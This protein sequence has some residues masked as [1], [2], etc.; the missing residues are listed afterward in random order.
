MDPRRIYLITGFAQGFLW[1]GWAVA[2][3]PWWT[4]V[5]GLSPIQ[6]ILLGTALELTVLVGEVP[7][8][9]VADV[10]SRKWSVV[11]SWAVIAA[12]QVLAP[13]SEI[14]WLLIAWQVLWALGFTLQSGATTAW[15]T[16]ETGEDETGSIIRHAIVRSVGVIFGVLG[17]FAT[18]QI[19]I[20]ATMQIFGVGSGIFAVW[21]AV[22]MSETG[23]QPTDRSE[24][25][26]WQAFGET[27]RT[28]YLMTRRLRPLRIMAIAIALVAMAD[29]TIDRLD[30]RRMVDLGLPDISGE[31]AVYFFGL[32]WIVMT[33]LNIPAMIFAR[34]RA[35]NFETGSV[36]RLLRTLL[37]CGALGVLFMA[38][39]FSFA[40]AVVGWAMRDVVRE[41][42][43]PMAEA[44]TNNYATSEV[45]ATVLSFRAQASAAGE[46]VGGLLLGA[47]AQWVS[48][49]L[50]FGLAAL[51]MAASGAQFLRVQGD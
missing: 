36:A 51:L 2:A 12:A 16:D 34:R 38:I 43:E 6:L 14:F 37:W 32:A 7:T 18:L 25:S 50:A 8:G 41:T 31:G 11:A 44:W 42:V 30:V 22:V 46:V 13:V 21:L 40:L 27:M 24:T 47:V 23:F 26:A 15:V 20:T 10:F 9:V 5:L 4:V 29:E 48:L 1:A 3:V 45:R 17:A 39:G 28:G 35:E 49:G 19:S 33:A